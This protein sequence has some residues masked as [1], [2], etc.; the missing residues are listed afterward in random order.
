MCMCEAWKSFWR[1]SRVSDL[2]LDRISV[3]PGKKQVP[4]LRL[5]CPSGRPS[6][7]RDDKIVDGGMTRSLM[8]GMGSS[9]VG[10]ITDVVTVGMKGC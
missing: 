10:P 9:L 3:G 7:G 8:L 5:A 1:G 2:G 4:P 6:S